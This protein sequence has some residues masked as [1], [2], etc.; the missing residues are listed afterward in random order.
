MNDN[1]KAFLEGAVEGAK[2]T[3]RGFFAPVIAFFAWL[4]RVTD[5]ALDHP[6]TT[7][8]QA[9]VVAGHK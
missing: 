8:K 4:N 9:G 5:E 1:L 3:P 7:D 6:A 2:E